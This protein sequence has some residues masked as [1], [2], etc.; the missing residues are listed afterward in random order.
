VSENKKLIDFRAVREAVTME[1]VL[2]HYGL[3]ESMQR[4][5]DRLSGCCPL[6]QGS[7]PTQ[8]RVSITKNLWN[9]F[10]QCHIGGNVL[11]FIARKE[12]ASAYASAQKAIEWFDIPHD[13]VYVKNV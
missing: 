1:Q 6:H 2:K 12:D 7:N 13:K 11:D 4:N 9:C 3:L 5:G 10:G 8:F